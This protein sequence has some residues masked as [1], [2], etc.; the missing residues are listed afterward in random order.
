FR[1]DLHRYISGVLKNDNIFPLAIGG[2]LD[3]VHMFFELPPTQNLSDIMRRIKAVSSKWI[4]DNRLVSGK[5]QWQEGY[6][7]FS[8]R[9]S[10]RLNSSHVKISYAVFCLKKKR[11]FIKIN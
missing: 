6:G 4:N 5:F 8:D 3:H 11:N 2:W 1:D 7:A 10:T 9:K